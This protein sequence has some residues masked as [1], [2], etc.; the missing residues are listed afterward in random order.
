ME[1]ILPVTYFA[2]KVLLDHVL[3]NYFLSLLL[4]Y[5][6]RIRYDNRDISN[7]IVKII[8]FRLKK[9]LDEF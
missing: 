2:N 8:S 9:K 4:C 5:T 1:K 7:N 3:F 6:G